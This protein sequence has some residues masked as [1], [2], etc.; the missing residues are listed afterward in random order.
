MKGDPA[1]AQG[2]VLLMWAGKGRGRLPP[3]FRPVGG[4]VSRLGRP[5]WWAW[6]AVTAATPDKAAAV[7]CK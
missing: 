5:G 3:P 7:S 4:A 2:A 6:P 1:P